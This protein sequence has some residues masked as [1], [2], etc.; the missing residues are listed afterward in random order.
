ML[1]TAVANL[2]KGNSGSWV[3]GTTAFLRVGMGFTGSGTTPCFS[4]SGSVVSGCNAVFD[5]V[6]TLGNVSTSPAGAGQN[7]QAVS[8]TEHELDEVL[9]GG[10][11]GST[12]GENYSSEVSGVVLGSTDL[13]RYQSSGSTCASVTSTPSYA[14]NSSA[15]ACYS[16][17]GGSSA[18]VQM[19]QVG[20]GSDYGD[21]AT[22]LPNIPYIQDAFYPG[23]TNDYSPSSPEFTMMES[24]SYNGIVAEPSTL[25]LIAGAIG[26]LGWMR[27]RRVLSLRGA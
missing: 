15:I 8:V 12:I 16:I 18:L 1:A 6:I 4:A 26:G 10:G 5:G 23:T 21:F 7:A 20:G 19:N 14:T 3:L 24:I 2:S 25:A 27:R 17:N 11:S 22:T 9:G 13:Y